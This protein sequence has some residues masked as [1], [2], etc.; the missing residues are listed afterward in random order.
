[1]RRLWLDRHVTLIITAFVVGA[2]AGLANI[3]FRTILH[4]VRDLVFVGG[5]EAL[6][7]TGGGLARLLMPLLPVSGALVIVLISARFPGEITG[8]TFHRFLETVNVKGGVLRARNL[9]FKTIGVMI[10]KE[11]FYLPV[12]DGEGGMTGIISIHDVRPVLL[13][14]K[15]KGVV[16]AGDLATERVITL[17]PDDDLN[18]AAE[19][20]ALKDIDEIP[21]V[22]REDPRKVIG[23]ISRADVFA[24]YNKEVLTRILHEY[25]LRIEH[26][27]L[28]EK[29]NVASAAGSARG[30]VC[31]H[32]KR[33][34]RWRYSPFGRARI[35]RI[36]RV[37]RGSQ[38]AKYGVASRA[39][40]MRHPGLVQ[41]PG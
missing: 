34:G 13:D 4:A 38:Y 37:A 9:F 1:M 31:A 15:V 16:R 2:L 17:F 18:D 28:G 6:H 29:A 39:L 3:V 19:S 35:C 27:A 22:S 40:H 41:Y 25:T 24:A 33:T 20:F 36:C 8:Y 23:M 21:V 12:V 30:T 10:S 32:G 7:I 14:E 5:Q 26:K 11:R